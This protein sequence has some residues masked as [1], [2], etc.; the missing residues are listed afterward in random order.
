MFGAPLS[1]FGMRRKKRAQLETTNRQARDSWWEDM[2]VLLPKSIS[3]RLKWLLEDSSSRWKVGLRIVP[4][5]PIQRKGC[6]LKGAKKEEQPL[7]VGKCT[8][9]DVQD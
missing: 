1:K 5:P 2:G 8:T 9:R 7:E 4:K 3:V 6:D